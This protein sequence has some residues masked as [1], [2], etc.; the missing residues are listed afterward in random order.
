M[1]SLWPGREL[2]FLSADADADADADTTTDVG[3]H[4]RPLDVLMPF[5]IQMYWSNSGSGGLDEAHHRRWKS[6]G[7]L[8]SPGIGWGTWNI[9]NDDDGDDETEHLLILLEIEAQAAEVEPA[10]S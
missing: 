6:G 7:L 1:F 3:A 9:R 5:L 8:Q 10:S 4:P 2:F